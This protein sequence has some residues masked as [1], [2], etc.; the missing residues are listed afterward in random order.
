MAEAAQA[1]HADRHMVHRLADS[2]PQGAQRGEMAPATRHPEDPDMSTDIIPERWF[3]KFA[4]QDAAGMIQTLAEDGSC[5]DIIRAVAATLLANGL[6][7]GA[8]NEPPFVTP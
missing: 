5:A 7:P 4:E 6:V 2:R 1:L 8:T 3:V